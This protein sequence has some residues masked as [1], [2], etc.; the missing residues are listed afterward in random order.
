MAMIPCP[1]CGKEMSDSSGA[2]PSCGYRIKASKKQKTLIRIA[3]VLQIVV[4]ILC[5]AITV[6]RG[7]IIVYRYESGVDLESPYDEVVWQK[8]RSFGGYD[9]ANIFLMS[10]GYDGTPDGS[11]EVQAITFLGILALI[12]IILG[13][14]LYWIKQSKPKSM[15]RYWI[16]PLVV[17]ALL[18][19]QAFLLPGAY[20]TA[21]SSY[22]S[23]PYN[24]DF[25]PYIGWY[26]TVFFELITCFLGIRAEKAA[27][28]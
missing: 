12:A 4:L 3:I 19:I 10:T 13:I 20:A 1:E 7:E 6:Y 11:I 14:I 18:L 17:I 27:D 8:V 26:I 23:V 15:P 28:L 9:L 25:K 24:I 21:T 16:A 2:C 22:E 5:S